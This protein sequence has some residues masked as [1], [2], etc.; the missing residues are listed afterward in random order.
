MY[1]MPTPQVQLLQGYL[2]YVAATYVAPT[3]SSQVLGPL[4]G[5]ESG[6]LVVARSLQAWLDGAP[7][8]AL[9]SICDALCGHGGVW[10]ISAACRVAALLF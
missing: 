1:S 2:A 10:V 7:C 5:P 8:F 6:G 3:F 4:L 9:A